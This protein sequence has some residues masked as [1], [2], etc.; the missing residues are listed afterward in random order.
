M[1]SRAKKVCIFLTAILL[2]GVLYYF[3][4]YFTGFYIPCLVRLVTGQK[5]TGGGKTHMILNIFH[6]NF[7]AAFKSNQLL[8]L[9]S[10]IIAAMIAR[11]IYCYIKYEKHKTDKW[12]DITSFI[13]IGMFILFTVL[14]NI[15]KF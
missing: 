5:K 8:F 7:K 10:P 13:L 9:T 2:I 4:T 14:R 1:K 3:V 15:Y 6:L 12:I 11:E